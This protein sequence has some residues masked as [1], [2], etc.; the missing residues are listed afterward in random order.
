MKL[1]FVGD[2]H[3]QVNDLEDCQKLFNYVMKVAQETGAVV[4]FSGDL[5]NDH[6]IVH[7]EVQK[8]WRDNFDRLKYKGIETI[9][10]A[11]NHDISGNKASEACALLAHSEQAEV[12]LNPFVYYDILFSPFTR[13]DNAFVKACKDHP[14][15]KTVICH[16]TFLG[17]QF[18]NGFKVFN[19]INPNDIPQELVI[20]GHHHTPHSFGKVKYYGSPRWRTLSDA[21]VD[22]AIWL[23]EFD[24]GQLVKETSFSTNNVCRKIWHF[25][26]SE[27][28]PVDIV[29]NS[30]DKYFIDIKGSRK[31]VDSRKS[32]YEGNAKIRTFVTDK[33]KTKIK[34]SDG[35]D[36]AFSKW[37]SNFNATRGTDTNILQKLAGERLGR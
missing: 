31:W 32:L 23:L 9:V 19:G 6:S 29:F 22:R 4:F 3:A 28:N 11:G 15:V 26:D 25:E 27:K 17:A 14:E 24:N 34:E 37:T 10:I 33:A 30:K 5:Y 2:P 16:A 7:L 18:D 13:D 35:I 12:I 21:N 8:F 1:L 36:I 20:S